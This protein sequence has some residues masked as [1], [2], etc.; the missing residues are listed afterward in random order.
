MTLL[1][2]THN[3]LLAKRCGREQRLQNGRFL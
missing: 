3:E 1:F 2:V